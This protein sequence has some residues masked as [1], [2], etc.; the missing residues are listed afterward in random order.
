MNFD[1]NWDIPQKVLDKFWKDRGYEDARDAW[2]AACAINDDRITKEQYVKIVNQLKKDIHK[3]NERAIHN[4]KIDYRTGET[5]P[6]FNRD[7][8]IRLSKEKFTNLLFN[9]GIEF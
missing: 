9:N 3:H 6:K 4:Y 8:D 5:Y 1:K 7:G 2:N